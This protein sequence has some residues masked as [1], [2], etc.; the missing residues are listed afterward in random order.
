MDGRG[1]TVG[2]LETTTATKYGTGGHDGFSAS[3][4]STPMRIKATGGGA[5]KYAQVFRERLGV[6]L[7][8]EDEMDCLIRGANFLLQAIRDEAFTYLDGKQTFVPITPGTE[9][10]PYLL[11][12]IG[13]GVSLIKADSSTAFERVSGTSLGGGTFW[14]LCRLLTGARSFDEMLELSMKGDNAKVDMLVG[15]IYGGLD[16][17]KI[18][19]SSTTIASSFGLVVAEQVRASIYIVF[20]SCVCK[21]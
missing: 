3:A 4:R 16:Y 9:L 17:D 10:F 1:S 2:T 5:Y 11:C 21:I 20:L 8:K 14:G 7:E 6:V 13:S 18:G 15:D 12:N 19:L